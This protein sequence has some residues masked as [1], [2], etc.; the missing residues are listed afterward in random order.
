MIVLDASLVIAHLA[1]AGAHHP[2]ATTFFREHADAD[3]IV[4]MLTL[5]EI[6]VGPT[7]VG[8]ALDVTRA[9]A[10]LGID[11]WAP[12]SG[13]AARLAHLRVASGLQLPDCC[14]LDAA[15]ET[16]SPLATFDERLAGAARAAG[17]TVVAV[18]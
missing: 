18:S 15:I 2:R 8:R 4:H 10:S 17:V 14:V 1:A 6:L 5:T 13:S 11:E 12:P 7:R 9:L 3:F 16:A